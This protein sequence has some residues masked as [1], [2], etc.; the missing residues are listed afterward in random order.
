MTAKDKKLLVFLKVCSVIYVITSILAFYLNYKSQ[1]MNGILMGVVALLTPW[2]VPVLFKILKLK[3]VY[4]IYVIYLIFVY[5]ASLV[6]SCLHG[7]SLPYF[8]KVLH[9]SSGLFAT[10][11]A[12]M[13]FCKIKNVKKVENAADYKIFLL[14]INSMNLAIAALWEFY[15]YALLIFFNNDAVNHYTTGVH[16]SLTDMICAFIAGLIITCLIIRY[17]KTGK[18][19]F[20]ISLYESFYDK[21]IAK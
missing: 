19:N 3:P 14:F 5:F 7:Y 9:F 10:L 4:E 11:I 18:S 13:L 20:F 12:V 1:N 16:D 21:N 15:E 17:Y 6:G 8:D 2:I